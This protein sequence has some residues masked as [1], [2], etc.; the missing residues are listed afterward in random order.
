MSCEWSPAVQFPYS[1]PLSFS[2]LTHAEQYVFFALTH[3]EQYVLFVL[4]HT[5]Q[6]VLF[7][8][9]HTE[10]YV[11]FPRL[12]QQVIWSETGTVWVLSLPKPV[13]LQFY[14]ILQWTQMVQDLLH[15][16]FRCCSVGT[17]GPRPPTCIRSTAS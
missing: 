8:L 10:R 17:A 12:V 3:A 2:V 15:F 13:V 1:C 14:G 4:T 7:V 16:P 5:E 6:Y 11:L 9:T